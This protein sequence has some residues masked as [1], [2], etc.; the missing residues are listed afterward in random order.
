MV[1]VLS[2]VNLRASQGLPDPS[3]KKRDVLDELHELLDKF[4]S[5]S[6]KTADI[7]LYPTATLMRLQIRSSG[8][9]VRIV[10]AVQA[11]I[12]ILE[13]YFYLWFMSGLPLESCIKIG[14]TQNQIS[15]HTIEF[16][17]LNTYCF[18]YSKWDLTRKQILSVLS[19]EVIS[20]FI[21]LS[22]YEAKFL[23]FLRNYYLTVPMFHPHIDFARRL[24]GTV[25]GSG[26]TSLDNSICN[27]LLFVICYNRYMSQRGLDPN[28]YEFKI[29]VCGD[30][31]VFGTNFDLNPKEFTK[32]VDSEFGVTMGLELPTQPP[33]VNK[34]FFLGS[35]WIDG[36]PI[37]TEKVMVASVIFGSGNFPKMTPYELLTSR[38]LEVFGNSSDCQKYWDRLGIERIPSRV[39]HFQELKEYRENSRG[40]IFPKSD[41]GRGVWLDTSISR[42]EL[43]ILWKTR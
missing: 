34:L 23:K 8:L 12:S 19:F 30:D 4:Y 9:K 29:S 6:L 42:D 13:S 26:F 20:R 15:E 14:L 3:L 33:K 32:F 21:N 17:N 18:D 2:R 1:E 35:L 7:I 10:H 43:S 40:K 41:L 5:K 28:N 37:R 25:S 27:Y 36:N 39:F 16:E 31:L 11:K 22:S 24:M 38:F